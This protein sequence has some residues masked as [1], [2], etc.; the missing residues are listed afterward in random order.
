M[1]PTTPAEII[2]PILH[3]WMKEIAD[4]LSQVIVN[5][6]LS[7]NPYAKYFK[8]NTR[9]NGANGVQG[10]LS[11]LSYLRFLEMKVRPPKDPMSKAFIGALANWIMVRKQRFHLPPTRKGGEP[12][13]ITTR[14][15]AVQLAYAMAISIA[16]NQEV[17]TPKRWY[18]SR[19]YKGLSR[20]EYRVIDALSYDVLDKI[21]I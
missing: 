21:Q 17:R 11:F 5:R 13:P 6:Q 16:R 20:L 1:N 14:K 12:I 19:V 2:K 3:N 7:L 18:Q 4:D 15:Q 10:T 8:A 9:A